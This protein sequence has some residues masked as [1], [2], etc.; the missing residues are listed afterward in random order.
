MSERLQTLAASKAT[1][2]EIERAAL[3]EGMRTL[4]DDGLSKVAA[5]L[6]S[7]EELARVTV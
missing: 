7:L 1:R 5:G 6:T 3:Q 2:E 4:W